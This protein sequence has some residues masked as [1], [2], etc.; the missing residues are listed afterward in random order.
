MGLPD[1]ADNNPL[2]GSHGRRTNSATDD[3]RLMLKMGWTPRD[4][5]EYVVTYL[6]QDGDKNSAPSAD[7]KNSKFGSGQSITKRVF[8]LMVRPKLPMILRCKV[9][10]ITTNSKIRS[11]NTNQFRII[12]QANTIT[13]TMTITVMV[14][15]C[16][17]I[18][19]F[20][21]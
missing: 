20:V 3:K 1:S 11:I 17:S 4:A 15:I 2:A 12:E 13:A 19:P 21:K 7:N 5:D 14:P 10:S 18:L 9:G 8:T 6:K 16:V